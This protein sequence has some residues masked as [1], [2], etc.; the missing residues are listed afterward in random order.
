[1]DLE[2]GDSFIRGQLPLQSEEEATLLDIERLELQKSYQLKRVDDIDGR[3]RPG[4]PNVGNLPDM[5]ELL[6]RNYRLRKI[7]ETLGELTW[8]ATQLWLVKREADRI[9]G[10]RTD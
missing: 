7:D 1:M 9:I 6:Y 2:A 8:K 5:I 3:L 4:A 10:V